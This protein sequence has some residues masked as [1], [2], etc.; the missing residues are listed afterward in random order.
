MAD[1]NPSRDPDL[2]HYSVDRDLGYPA[3]PLFAIAADVERYPEFLPGWKA[4]RRRDI[5]ADEYATDQMLAFGPVRERFTSM[6][7]LER[8]HR[9][10][11]VSHSRTFRHFEVNW[12]FVPLGDTR[13]RVHLDAH[14]GFKSKAMRLLV[15][16][17]LGGQLNDILTA[18]ER[19][20]RDC[21]GA[22]ALDRGDGQPVERPPAPR[23]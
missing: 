1:L 20:A 19:R 4:V 14:M 5:A 13:C 10:R 16:K 3:E 2:L 21:L 17:V 11:V 7:Q 12:R 8:P 23:S 6:T 15:G 22:A 18:F 9:I